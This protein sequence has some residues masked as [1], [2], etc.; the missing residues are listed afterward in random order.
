MKYMIL[1][2]IL[3][4]SASAFGQD[5]KEIEAKLVSVFHKYDEWNDKRVDFRDKDD[6]DSMGICYDSMHTAE[7][8][9]T[10]LLLYYTSKYPTTLQYDFK[11]LRKV[12]IGVLTSSDKKFRI[13]CWLEKD[14][15]TMIEITNIFQFESGGKVY[16]EYINPYQTEDPA[17]SD[18]EPDL[19][20]YDSIYSLSLGNRTIYIGEWSAIE[21]GSDFGAGFNFFE[22][23]D[24]VLD[25]EL[26]IIKQG[27]HLKSSISTWYRP[28]EDYVDITKCVKAGKILKIRRG[29]RM[30]VLSKK[31]DVYW[32]NGK[33]YDKVRVKKKPKSKV[34]TK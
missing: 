5:M 3:F 6:F 13:Y 25:T 4:G 21:D 14:H 17:E 10:N 26:P 24:S 2:F 1:I 11:E 32:F 7:A 28:T 31:Y 18:E 12:R 8:S 23:K 20:D 15:G 16:S 33:Y 9:F 30:G 29:N 34:K 19:T 22:V 27:K